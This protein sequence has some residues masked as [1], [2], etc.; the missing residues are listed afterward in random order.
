VSFLV[1]CFDHLKRKNYAMIYVYY[2]QTY[3]FIRGSRLLLFLGHFSWLTCDY[4][5]AELFGIV[6]VGLLWVGLVFCVM[7]STRV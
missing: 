3:W 5:H 6:G 7:T 1:V 4:N 2:L